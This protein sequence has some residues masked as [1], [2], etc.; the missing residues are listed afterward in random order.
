MNNSMYC[1]K[2]AQ[3][4]FSGLDN[5]ARVKKI[6]YTTCILHISFKQVVE[7]ES[8]RRLDDEDISEKKIAWGP[9]PWK[10]REAGS[11]H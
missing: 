8:K 5:N 3:S 2:Y 11:N 7:I 10:L 9:H 4:R 6:S 1:G